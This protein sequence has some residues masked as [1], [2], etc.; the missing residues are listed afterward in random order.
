MTSIIMDSVIE[1]CHTD[2]NLEE[3]LKKFFQDICEYGSDLYFH[4]HSFTK[5]SA[6]NI[7]NYHG[8]DLYYL[9]LDRKRVVGYGILRGWDEG[10][11][12]P[13]LGMII[14]PTERGKGLGKLLMEFLH[15]VARLRGAKHIRLKVYPENK[16]ALEL[17]KKAGYIFE[18][19]L[20]DDQL[21]GYKK[22]TL[23]K[24]FE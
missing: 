24:A 21:V 19:E 6:Y 2:L 14:H 1:I 13:S 11:D 9:L 5:E 16:I 12:I 20:V 22:I 3:P 15:S 18:E 23:D 8:K 4:P 10:F 7:A 17:Y